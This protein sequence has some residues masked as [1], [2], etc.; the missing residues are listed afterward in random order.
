GTRN[1]VRVALEKGAGRFIHTSSIS[2]YG[3]QGRYVDEDT[4]SVSPTSPVNYERTK[5]LAEQEVRKGID[6]GLDAVIL[7]PT[8]IIGPGDRHNWARSLFMVRDGKVPGVPPGGSPFCDVREVARMHLV[9]YEKA[10]TGANYLL[11][12]ESVPYSALFEELSR[13][14]GQDRKMMRL[15]GFVIKAVGGLNGALSRITGKEP[16]ITPELA[17]LMSSTM[18]CSSEKAQRELGY[19][20]CDWRQSLRDTRDWLIEEGLFQHA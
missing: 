14:T 16:D 6:Q 15:P 3:R 1:M 10:P 20:D 17:R 12:G 19:R 18:K 9:A 13:L 8:G 11:G 2:A 4:P 7:N 5:W